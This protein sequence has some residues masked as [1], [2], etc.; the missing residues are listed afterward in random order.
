MN[1]RALN[2]SDEHLLPECLE[3]LESTQGRNVSNLDY[4]KKILSPEKGLLLVLENDQQHILAVAGAQILDGVTFEYYLPFGEEI[5]EKLRASKVG[6]LSTMSVHKSVQGQGWGQRLLKARMDWLAAQG[7][8]VLVGISWVSGTQNNSA[9]V[10]Q[11]LGF[12]AIREVENFFVESSRRDN[13][14]CPTCI[15][16]PCY[17]PGILFVKEL[18]KN[19]QP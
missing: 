19:F 18:E 5:V 7:R 10:F 4:L 11:K 1:I 9:N 3:L 6:S 15:T 8:N 12:K 14:L 17:C 16:A 2:H 13:L